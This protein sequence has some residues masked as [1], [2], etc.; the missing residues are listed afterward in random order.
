M[1]KKILLLLLA[2]F[3]VWISAG[4]C[5]NLENIKANFL[6]GDFKKVI[7]EAEAILAT[8]GASRPQLDDVHYFL[9]LA[10]LKDS[11]YNS[12]GRNFKAV[13][14]DPRDSRY[15]EEAEIGSGDSY[16]LAGDTLKAQEVFKGIISRGPKS[17]FRPQ[18]LYRMSRLSTK[19]GNAE[20]SE[21]YLAILRQ[22]YPQSAELSFS[23]DIYAK[24]VLKPQAPEIMAVI[25]QPVTLDVP[26]AQVDLRP[27][28]PQAAAVSVAPIN[29]AQD[30]VQVRFSVQVGSF[31]NADNAG[32]LTQRLID[33][34]YAAYIEESGAESGEVSYRVKV[35]KFTSRESA[36]SLAEALLKEGYPARI[37]P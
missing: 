13:L 10:Y 19:A 36:V 15:K 16:A 8:S 23:K 5:L 14:D 21:A 37:A 24:A 12:A 22:E 4:Y 17:R 11:N 3:L 28:A 18:A 32:K 6:K 25:L 1:K 30:I 34:G 20:E 27:Q 31:S 35:G 29:Q 9:G 26:Q 2:I 33:S 7:S